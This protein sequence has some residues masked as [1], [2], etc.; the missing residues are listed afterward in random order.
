MQVLNLAN[1][2]NYDTWKTTATSNSALDVAHLQQNVVYAL[3]N[4]YEQASKHRGMKVYVLLETGSH[5]VMPYQ[6]AL[7]LNQAILQPFVDFI[8]PEF[9]LVVMPLNCSTVEE[10]FAADSVPR[11]GSCVQD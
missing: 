2:A 4:A 8:N 6:V 11:S 5:Y 10:M 9:D 3:F 7:Y 1:F